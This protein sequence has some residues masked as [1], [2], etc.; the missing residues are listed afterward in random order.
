[1]RI[2][3]AYTAKIKCLLQSTPKS[4]KE[5]TDG[6]CCT[7]AQGPALYQVVK[8]INFSIQLSTLRGASDL[9]Q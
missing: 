2:V 9:M 6:F 1:M 7:Q 4:R 5:I 8:N 3:H